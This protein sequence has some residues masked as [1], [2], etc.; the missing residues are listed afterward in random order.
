MSNMINPKEY[1]NKKRKKSRDQGSFTLRKP[2]VIEKN[3]QSEE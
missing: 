3:K 2:P 1:Q